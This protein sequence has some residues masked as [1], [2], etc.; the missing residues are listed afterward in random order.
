MGIS[1]NVIQS[2]LRLFV[3]ISVGFLSCVTAHAKEPVHDVRV[4]VDLSGSMKKN[5]PKNL[6]QPAVRLITN[7]LPPESK[8]GVWTFGKYVNMLVK[9][10]IVDDNWKKMAIAESAKINSAGLYTNIGG[11]LEKAASSWKESS[12]DEKRSIILLTDGMVDISKDTAENEAERQRI[13]KQILPKLKKLGITIHTIALSDGADKELMSTLSGHTDGW[14][15]AVQDA[16]GL[17]KAFLKIFAQAAPQDTV[18]LTDNKFKID[19]SIEEFTLLVFKKPG[20]EPSQLVTPSQQVIEQNS[21]S[22]DVNWFSDAGYYL[23]TVKNPE[24]GEWGVVADVDPDNRV[25]VVSDMKLKTPEVPNNLLASETINYAAALLQEG[26]I[27]D[28]PSF[29]SLVEFKLILFRPDGAMDIVPL[30]DDGSD[31]DPVKNDGEFATRLDVGSESGLLKV[32]L[33]AES[34]TFERSREYGI[35]IAGEPF[36]FETVISEDPEKPHQLVL[37]IKEDIV[38]PRSLFIKT[39]MTLPD[40]SKKDISISDGSLTRRTLDIDNTPAGGSYQFIFHSEGESQ[41]NRRFYLTSKP[42]QIEFPS[43]PGFEAPK[44]EPKPEPAQQ[45]PKSETPEVEPTEVTEEPAVEEPEAEEGLSIWIWVAIG[46]VVNLLLV[47]GGW[48]VAKIIKKRNA[49]KAQ[50]LAAK[51]EG[52]DQVS[53][54]QETVIAAEENKG[55]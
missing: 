10:G 26:E 8:A 20:A 28:K 13:L 18:P 16:D 48:F 50:A 14:F 54:D 12:K 1:K 23:I 55:G 5:D 42:Y 34:P 2:S 39:E 38:N 7:L 11:V 27:I 51:L 37:N 21:S 30:K 6:R 35:N 25:M 15:E 29:L 32:T 36:D 43:M 3:L 45:E 9:H 40:G 49:E 44:Q 46:L 17:Q 52:D 4:L 33:I 19:G 31:G 47:A 41:L 53:G 22:S 24:T